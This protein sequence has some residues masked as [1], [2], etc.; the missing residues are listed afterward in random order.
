MSKH[1]L[2]S[3]EWAEIDGNQ[4]TVGISTYA[5]SEV[6]EIIH[7][8]LPEV[9]TVISGSDAVAE[10]ESVKSVNDIYSPVSGTISAVNEAVAAS[11]EIVNSSA[12]SD[13]WL[14]KVTISGANAT[15]GLMDQTA[16]DAHIE[17]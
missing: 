15:D 1:Y 11:P 5:A 3:H 7:V 2:K 12:E 16:Y 8:E 10:I 13:G 14:F 6:G 9:G 17:S 4:A